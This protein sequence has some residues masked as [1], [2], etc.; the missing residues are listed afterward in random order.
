MTHTYIPSPSSIPKFHVDASF[1]RHGFIT[2]AYMATKKEMKKRTPQHRVTTSSGVKSTRP[3]SR[4][5]EAWSRLPDPPSSDGRTTSLAVKVISAAPAAP[6]SFNA[7]LLSVVSPPSLSVLPL[8]PLLLLLPP[9]LLLTPPTRKI[10]C[11]ELE[12]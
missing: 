8:L 1:G 5:S 4:G 9:P 10:P 2:W 6:F 12:P 11:V 3:R 7:W